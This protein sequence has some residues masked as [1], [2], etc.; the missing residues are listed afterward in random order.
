MPLV[1]AIGAAAHR[2]VPAPADRPRSCGRCVRARERGFVRWLRLRRMD[3]LSCPRAEG[4]AVSAHGCSRFSAASGIRRT[5]RPFLDTEWRCN[6]HACHEAADRYRAAAR[7]ALLRDMSTL[8][9]PD[10]QRD[11]QAVDSQSARPYRADFHRH[12]C[13]QRETLQ[14]W[15]GFAGDS[16][17][18]HLSRSIEIYRL[19][20]QPRALGRPCV[21]PRISIR[22]AGEMNDTSNCC[23]SLVRQLFYRR[24]WQDA[25][26]LAPD[27]LHAWG[28]SQTG[29]AK[30]RTRTITQPPAERRESSA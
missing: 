4:N 22:K 12:L 19:L 18:A 3:V 9:P 26:G 14:H 16:A 8:L 25:E 20:G 28:P 17:E 29:R 27:A 2:G 15:H 13:R 10:H 30:S 24:H 1:H 7:A 23:T 6:Q 21:E 11:F 5:E